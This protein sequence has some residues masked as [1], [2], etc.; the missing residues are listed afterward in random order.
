MAIEQRSLTLDEFLALPEQEPALE[1]EPDGTVSRRVSPRGQHSVLQLALCK[2]VNDFARP[3]H[4][5]LAFPELRTVFAG[6]AYVPDV[7]VYR[8][9]RIPQKAD[10]KVANDFR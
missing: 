5:A 6:A 10:G 4:L 9:E 7:V 3:R 1:R 8:W 2:H